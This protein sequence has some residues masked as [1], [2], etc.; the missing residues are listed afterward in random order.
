M[1]GHPLQSKDTLLHLVFPTTKK[2]LQCLAGLFRFWQQQ[3]LHLGILLQSIHQ[4]MWKAAS[5]KWGLEQE[6]ALQ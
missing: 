1:S 5:S 3:Y 2:E 6:R 4:R